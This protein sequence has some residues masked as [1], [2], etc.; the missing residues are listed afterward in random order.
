MIVFSGGDPAEVQGQPQQLAGPCPWHQYA[1]KIGYSERHV[2][3][4]LNGAK[5]SE[6]GRH[7]VVIDVGRAPQEWRHILL[8]MCKVDKRGQVRTNADK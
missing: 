3:R 5:V 7:G 2:R 4:R 6:G 8:S 1:E